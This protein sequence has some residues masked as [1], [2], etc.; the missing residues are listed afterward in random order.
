MFPF[1]RFKKHFESRTVLSWE[2][3]VL[4]IKNLQ[5]VLKSQHFLQF[6]EPSEA[7][8]TVHPCIEK[9]TKNKNVSKCSFYFS[10]ELLQQR[11]S[12][13]LSLST[14]DNGSLVFII[15]SSDCSFK[16]CFCTENNN[17]RKMRIIKLLVR[18]IS[19]FC[20]SV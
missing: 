12:C 4:Q 9:A 1:M 14:L 8:L 2:R 20:M 16:M 18:V 3:D 11:G 15:V 5:Y 7:H 13:T 10:V 19:C 6:V 17:E